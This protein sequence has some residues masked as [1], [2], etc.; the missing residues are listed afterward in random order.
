MI[1]PQ[2]KICFIV[3]FHNVY[4]S[5]SLVF[6]NQYILYIMVKSCALFVSQKQTMVTF[7][8]NMKQL[9]VVT[10]SCQLWN[11]TLNTAQ[12]MG[13]SKSYCSYLFILFKILR[14]HFFSV[15][16]HTEK[17]FQYYDNTHPLVKRILGEN[18]ISKNSISKYGLRI[19]ST[20]Y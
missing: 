14:K 8:T 9:K 2:G 3:K 7:S 13:L 15:D 6:I 17:N 19:L 18:L 4:M 10:S 1:A 12:F 16:I 20:I 11:S 5:K